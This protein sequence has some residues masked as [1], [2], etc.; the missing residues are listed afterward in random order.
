MAIRSGL[1]SACHL[2]GSGNPSSDQLRNDLEV[3]DTFVDE[4]HLIRRLERCRK[5][6]QLYFYEFTEEID[7]LD[8]NDPQYRTW[9]PVQD[10]QSALELSKLALGGLSRYP[11]IRSDFP[12]DAAAPTAPVW[13]EGRG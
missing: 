4:S 11:A 5:C 1:P 12:S 2:R 6:G 7:W 10:A 13:V 8:G 3:I 9:I